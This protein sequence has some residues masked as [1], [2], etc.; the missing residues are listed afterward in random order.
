MVAM[1]L[2]LLAFCGGLGLAGSRT[3]DSDRYLARVMRASDNGSRL[4]CSPSARTVSRACVDAAR[5]DYWLAVAKCQNL[6]SQDELESCRDEA[7]EA[8]GESREECGEQLAA[9]LE[10]C[11][12]LGEAP[13]SPDI[14]PANFVSGIDNPLLPF[15]PGTIWTYE[16]ET[17]DGTETI[18]VSVTGATREILGVT[19]TVVHDMVY[20][21]GALIED[22]FDWYAQ[23]VAGNVWYFGELS[24]ELEDGVIVNLE[25]SWESGVDGA[26][27]GIVMPVARRVGDVY[28]QEFLL[29]EAE[30]MGEVASLDEDVSVPYGDFTGALM[31][32]DF[33]PVEPDALEEKFYAPGVGLVL[34]VDPETGERVE[35]I[36][37]VK[38]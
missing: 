21:D 23:D 7:R 30:D 20:L 36:D 38:P 6:S 35:L 14:D 18:I 11:G 37:V 1:A 16:G 28:R 26:S 19:C 25:G 29:G 10:V 3:L 12:A 22:T 32:Y 15:I 8:L 34:E 33:T 2:P 24:Y 27:P 4:G 17:E 13:Y 5:S 9:R 31:T